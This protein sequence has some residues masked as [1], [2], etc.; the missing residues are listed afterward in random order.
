MLFY[1]CGCGCG[2][3]GGIGMRGGEFCGRSGVLLGCWGWGVRRWEMFVWEEG[4]RGDVGGGG[5]GWGGGF[6]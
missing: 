4:V 2:G 3:G 5:L 1:F 6:F